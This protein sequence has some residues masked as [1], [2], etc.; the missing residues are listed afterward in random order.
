MIPVTAE[1][2]R[3]LSTK[4]G[5][6]MVLCLTALN[7]HDGD[8]AKAEEWLHRPPSIEDRLNRLEFKFKQIS[9]ELNELKGSVQ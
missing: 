1:S 3:R 2:V 4:T 9:A 5:R 7:A 8:E 6:P